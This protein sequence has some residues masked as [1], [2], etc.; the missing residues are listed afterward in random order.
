[1]TFLWA[2]LLALLLVAVPVLVGGYLWTQRRRR[3]VG[4]RY[5]S[6]SLLRDVV[7]RSNRWR[8]HVPFALLLASVGAIVLALARPAL[9]LAVPATGT[10]VI[11]V[12]DVSRSMCS[13]DIPPTRLEVAE[14]AAADFVR[15]QPSGTN[16]GLVAF[17]SFA[18]IVQPPTGDRDAVIAAIDH[19]TTGRWTAIGSGILAAIDAIAAADPSVPRSVPPGRPG[20]AP[21]PVLPGANPPDVIVLLTDG[22][23]NI[24]PDPM[25]AAQQAADRGLK[26][27][28]IG[29]GT[30][31]GGG[32]SITCAPRFVGKEPDA[33]AAPGLSRADPNQK[34]GGGR[35]RRGLD[36]QALLA[37]AEKTGAT[38]HPASSAAE[39]QA[40]FEGLPASMV[41]Q[42]EVVEV[43]AGFV[44]VG[45]L[46]LALSLL[47]GRMW[48]P[49]P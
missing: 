11:L 1:M 29:Y 49:L 45:G 24:G 13:A 16:I 4:V 44:A 10:N 35:S 39:L 32:V 2:W 23:N 40:V 47:L 26:V 30:Y 14:Q 46:L 17:S 6:L 21:A 5:S 27:Y 33:S 31:S 12:M 15:R 37:V 38:Y 8:R 41:V 22:A 25:E 34:R 20:V 18:A 3:P 42:H 48:R 19:L 9:V 7:P 43:S 28:T 36:E